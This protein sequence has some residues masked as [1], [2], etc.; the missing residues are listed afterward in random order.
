MSLTRINGYP[1]DLEVSASI[2]LTADITSRPI[3]S[4][5]QITDHIRNNPEEITLE[6]IVSDTPIGA[7]KDDDTRKIADGTE[8]VTPYGMYDTPLPSED[9]YARLIQ[10]RDDKKL[11]T[12]ESVSLGKLA[13]MAMA[14]LSPKFDATSTGGLFF[15]VKFKRVRIVTNKRTRVAVKTTLPGAGGKGKA[16]AKTGETFAVD[17]KITWRHGVPPGTP[18]RAG[19]AIEIVRARRRDAPGLSRAEY[20]SLSSLLQN[21]DLGS[22]MIAYFEDSS[23]PWGGSFG[24]EREITG[25]RRIAL[26]ADLNRD[27]SVA[28]GAKQSFAARKQGAA[29]AVKKLA[30]PMGLDFSRI[31]VG[32]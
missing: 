12:I 6:C 29:D 4:G 32:F 27:R 14:E 20:M 7:V 2:V 8:L 17:D 26:V 15:T 28:E 10:I 22:P 1:M 24:A 11:V 9:A 30:G 23:D 18:W 31:Q 16:K 25:A 3:E 5:A 21:A 13:D 19:N